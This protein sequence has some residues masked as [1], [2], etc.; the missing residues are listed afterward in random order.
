MIS[1][2]EEPNPPTPG[3]R[4]WRYRVKR[5]AKFSLAIYIGA[6]AILYFV[7][8]SLIFAGHSTQGALDAQSHEGFIQTVQLTAAEG[9]RIVAAYRPA[10][11]R[12]QDAPT[13]L[14]FSGNAMCAAW[15][16]SIISNLND[17][18][19]NVLVPDYIGFGESQ[20]VPSE[21]AC[22]ATAD[23]AWKYLMEQRAIPADRIVVMGWS[24][25][26][27]VAFDLASRQHPAGLITLSAFT[28]MPDVAQKSYPIIP[29]R[30]L[31]RSQFTNLLKVPK[32]KCPVLLF[33]GRKDTLVAPAN[34]EALLKA[35]GNQ[36]ELIWLD[37]AD[38]NTMFQAEPKT[39]N[40]G[41]ER[42]LAKMTPTTR[43]ATP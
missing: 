34:A 24:L 42:F 43:P 12:A 35:F 23:A 32:V 8:D 13:V 5:I 27:A 25:G 29:V 6:C 4:G 3:K 10:T 16:D 26:S 17:L 18:G 9:T 39:L 37:R 38:H 21:R 7:Q 2:M 41:L 36:A 15:C 20:G 30:L 22:Y 19:C 1:G 31:I 33:Q 40:D 14:F 28:S 11:G